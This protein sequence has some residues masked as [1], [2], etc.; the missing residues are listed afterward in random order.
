MYRLFP[1]HFV[2]NSLIALNV[3]F[4]NYLLMF[5]SFLPSKEVICAGLVCKDM[6][7]DPA[8]KDL[9]LGRVIRA[10]PNLNN[11]GFKYKFRDVIEDDPGKPQD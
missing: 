4:N 1:E 6:K 9:G 2:L 10:H 3:L 11:K 7:L 5:L 8:F